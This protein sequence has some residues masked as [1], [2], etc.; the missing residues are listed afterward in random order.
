MRLCECA[1]NNKCSCILLTKVTDQSQPKR[2]LEKSTIGGVELPS[3]F[4]HHDIRAPYRVGHPFQQPLEF[5]V[6][7]RDVI[8]DAGGAPSSPLGAVEFAWCCIGAGPSQKRAKN[9]VSG[10]GG[11]QADQLL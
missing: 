5:R 7:K 10:F 6:A 4:Q 9:E 1:A 8:A 3:S 2:L 11:Q